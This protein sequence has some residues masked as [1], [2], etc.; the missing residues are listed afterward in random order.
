MPQ[1][2][3]LLGNGL[4][5]AALDEE[6]RAGRQE[7][8]WLDLLRHLAVDAGVPDLNLTSK[9]LPLAYEELAATVSRRGILDIRHLR[10][11][12]ADWVSEIRSSALHREVAG[13]PIHQILTTNYDYALETAIDPKYDLV[14]GMG[15]TKYSLFRFHEIA[16]R[17]IWHMHGEQRVPTSLLLGHDHYV[18]Y[19]N[20]VQ[21]YLSL[22][23]SR[24]RA[25]RKSARQTDGASPLTRGN[26][27]F[28][29][30]KSRYSWVDLFLRNDLYVLGFG[31]DF[32]ELIFWW[33]LALRGRGEVRAEYSLPEKPW[34]PGTTTYFAIGNP[35]K[36]DGLRARVDVMQAFGVR[37]E[38]VGVEGRSYADAYR[39][40]FQRIRAE[41]A[42]RGSQAA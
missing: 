22:D 41:L 6:K 1:A 32:S 29:L 35:D 5:R 11:L 21:R 37:I 26:M 38:P 36:D 4:N 8:S 34:T 19:A 42:E 28:E 7:R 16:G 18:R 31:C 10:Q 13:L 20:S 40:C 12:V 25:P 9:P 27:A 15:E 39:E 17:Q 33:L 3:I 14:G 23:K 24:R 30:D 2:A